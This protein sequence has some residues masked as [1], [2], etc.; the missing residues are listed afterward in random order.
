[1]YRRLATA[2]VSSPDSTLA[3]S[4]AGDLGTNVV[5]NKH[6]VECH[7]PIPMTPEIESGAMLES[8]RANHFARCVILFGH[9]M[10][11]AGDI[12]LNQG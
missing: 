3:Q 8:I 2:G 4:H 1:M 5:H 11:L 7:L 9:P 6:S 12:R 10:N